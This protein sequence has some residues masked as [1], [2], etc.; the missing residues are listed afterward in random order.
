MLAI[1][2][3]VLV[4]AI[5][6][7][8][9][10][11]LRK[12][13]QELYKAIELRGQ[14]V[15]KHTS[16][17]LNLYALSYDYQS[18][19]LLL[20]EIVSSPD[21]IHAQVTSD[22][23]NVMDSA[24]SRAGPAEDRPRFEKELR[25]DGRVVGQL[26]VELDPSDIVRRVGEARNDLLLRELALIILV[27]LGEFIGLSYFIARPVSIITETLE[28][29]VDEDGQIRCDIPLA[30]R[31]EFGRLAQQFNR[32]RERLNHT[33]QRLQSRIEVADSRLLEINQALL[34]QSEELKSANQR[35]L[36]LSITDPLT[37]LYNRRHFEDMIRREMAHS[38][39]QGASCS[40]M[41]M[42]IDHFKR[43]NDRYGHA[44]GDDVLR[45]VAGI[46]QDNIR[47]GD[48]PCRIGGEEFVVACRST[49]ADEAIQLAERLRSAIESATFRLQDL[50]IRYTISVGIS[51][52]KTDSGHATLDTIFQNA[53]QA[54]YHSKEYGRN[55]TTHHQ[56]LDGNNNKRTTA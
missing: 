8:G 4:V 31:D 34:R 42:D 14:E 16:H 23:G 46:I 13:E 30:T 35:L 47:T 33:N 43:I 56:D 12:Q 1:L 6:I 25:Y 7:S 53:D 32:M 11:T 54:L 24:G 49:D 26:S 9:W 15:V 50:E 20:D 28:R 18:I 51:T 5:T 38:A 39:R 40:L 17:A 37:G 3:T 45:H 44:V 2:V 22:R 19:Q 41:I 52:I 29:N 21:I 36:E 55:R 27:V 10:I 48:I